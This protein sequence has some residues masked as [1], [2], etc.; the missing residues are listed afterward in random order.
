M[1]GTGR[2]PNSRTEVGG[3]SIRKLADQFSTP[4]YVYDAAVIVERI[5]D[6]K[7]FDV[8]R[9]QP[10]CLRA[11]YKMCL[12]FKIEPVSRLLLTPACFAVSSSAGHMPHLS[13]QS[14]KC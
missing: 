7:A 14:P 2:F 11:R 13:T 1:P 9:Q 8:V 5:N 3:V 4:T 12:S 6:L 10:P